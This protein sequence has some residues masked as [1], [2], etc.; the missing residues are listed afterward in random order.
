[1]HHSIDLAPL[2][3][4]WRTFKLQV[5]LLPGQGNR[6]KAHISQVLHERHS[7]SAARPGHQNLLAGA[8]PLRHERAPES[9]PGHLRTRLSHAASPT[10]SSGAQASQ[11]DAATGQ[12]RHVATLAAERSAKSLPASCRYCPLGRGRSQ[13]Q[14]SAVLPARPSRLAKA[15]AARGQ[16]FRRSCRHCVPTV[17]ALTAFVRHAHPPMTWRPSQSCGGVTAFSER[18]LS[19]SGAFFDLYGFFP[20]QAERRNGPRCSLVSVEDQRPTATFKTSR[21][22]YVCC[23][24][25]GK[26]LSCF[27]DR[28]SRKPEP[29]SGG[30]TTHLPALFNSCTSSSRRS[31]CACTASAYR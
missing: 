30:C 20:G 16:V 29:G 5:A 14:N 22:R 4:L 10:E 8:A 23:T 2:E 17:E 15:Q 19:D 13:P 3:C 24:S 31:L 11:S 27:E 9:V 21:V 28:A 7:D 12:P 26:V 1:M 25:V 18:K 6:P